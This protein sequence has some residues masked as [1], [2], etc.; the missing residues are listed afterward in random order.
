MNP[1]FFFKD[2][3]FQIFA[4]LNQ[5]GGRIDFRELQ[6]AKLGFK[7]GKVSFVAS[8]GW[9]SHGSIMVDFEGMARIK[10]NYFLP[11]RLARSALR[12][13]RLSVHLAGVLIMPRYLASVFS[14]Q[15]IEALIWAIV[16]SLTEIVTSL[17]SGPCVFM[18]VIY[19]KEG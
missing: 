11:I 2:F 13:A 8:D 3:A 4:L 16:A 18:H 5:V 9:L 12:M 17:W 1:A 7:L 19:Q 6:A 15:T 14:Y 10:I